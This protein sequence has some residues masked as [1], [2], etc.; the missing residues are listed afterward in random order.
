MASI[1]LGIYKTQISPRLEFKGIQFSFN[2]IS[3]QKSGLGSEFGRVLK[4]VDPRIRHFSKWILSVGDSVA[5]GD[6]NNDGLV[7]IFLTNM[8]KTGE[9]RSALYKN[10]GNFEFEILA[11]QNL[12]NLGII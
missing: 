2:S 9:F 12:G 6:Y 10:K 3:A 8:L 5:V 11:I 1:G 4:R 7:D